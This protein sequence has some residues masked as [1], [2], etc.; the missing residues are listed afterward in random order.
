MN[1]RLQKRLEN[2]ELHYVVYDMDEK[3]IRDWFVFDDY[4][5]LPVLEA[6]FFGLMS[7]ELAETFENKSLY[8]PVRYKSI[9]LVMHNICFDGNHIN[10]KVSKPL[11]ELYLAMKYNVFSSQI[12]TIKNRLEITSLEK[13][14]TDFLKLTIKDLPK[15]YLKNYYEVKDKIAK[16]KSDDVFFRELLHLC[17]DSE[18]YRA[19]EKA[20]KMLNLI[21]DLK[22]IATEYNVDVSDI[23]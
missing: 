22:K 7:Q 14:E 20:N 6:Y 9:L 16:N 17:S 5:N 3:L 19:K 11:S 18:Y 8:S 12:D 23:N 1:L 15:E 13:I 4:K 2:D 10:I 21:D